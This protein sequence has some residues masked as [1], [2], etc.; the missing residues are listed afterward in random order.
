MVHG[1]LLVD[2][3]KGRTSFSLV[4][5]LRKRFNQKRVGFA[6]TLD[7]LATG[8]MIMGLGEYTKLLPYLESADKVYE[9]EA[10]LG[11]ISTTYDAEGEITAC[12]EVNK[13]SKQQIEDLLN[14]KFIG[15]IE[16]IPPCFSAIKIDGE[17]AYLKARKGEQVEMKPRSVHI[18][19]IE[20]LNYNFPLIRLSVH[21]SK[22]TYIRSLVHDIGQDLNCGAYVKELRRTK[23]SKIDVSQA[24]NVDQAQIIDEKAVL[25]GIPRIKLDEDEAKKLLLGNFLSTDLQGNQQFLGYCGDKLLGILEVLPK[26]GIIKIKRKLNY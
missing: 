22:G 18:F 3:D 21:C 13:P 8:L 7:P 2:K 14:K 26:R 4:S 12:N 5:A 15:E 24:K 6:G 10:E 17:R 25:L 20:L 16:Q 11:F 19:D 23:I 9:V 1:F